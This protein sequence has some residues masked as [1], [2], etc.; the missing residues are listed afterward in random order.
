MYLISDRLYVHHGKEDQA[1]LAAERDRHLATGAEDLANGVC[2]ALA[3]GSRRLAAW[4]ATKYK[5]R[6]MEFD[7]LVTMGLIGL[8][9]AARTWD[10]ALGTFGTYGTHWARQ[11]ITRYLADASRLVRVPVYAHDVW[12]RGNQIL[13]KNSEH[14]FPVPASEA[15]DT[16]SVDERLYSVVNNASESWVELELLS[17]FVEALSSG[18]DHP[19]EWKSFGSRTHRSTRHRW[20][21]GAVGLDDCSDDVLDELTEME[22][23]RRLE[24]LPERECSVARR[25][26]GFD[27]PPQTLQ[28]IATQLGLTRERVRQIQNDAF[29]QLKTLL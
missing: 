11:A 21:F 7:D 14:D 4:V 1:A 5:P 26:L 27:G 22:W 24:Q 10:P 29:A 13:R 23:Q 17:E 8:H 9:R 3:L 20:I 19:D 16:G 28:Q 25:R 15:L 18:A 12:L 2:W 6:G